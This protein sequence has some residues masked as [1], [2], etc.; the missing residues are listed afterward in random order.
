M[1]F[2]DHFSGHAS[3][4]A[5]ARPTYPPALFDWLAERCAERHLAWD[6]GC[7]NGQAALALASRFDHVYASDPSAEQIAAAPPDPRIRY[8]VEAAEACSLADASADL[9]TVAQAYHW[10]DHARFAEQA[11]R[12]LKPG[13][14]LAVFNYAR[15]SVCPEID[16][17][18]DHLHD[19]TLAAD[20]PPER[21]FAVDGFHHLPMPFPE[22][23]DHPPAHFRLHCDWTLDQYL[24]YL[25]SWSGCQRYLKRTGLDPIAAITPAMADAWGAP[26]QPRA[27]IWPL[28]LRCARKPGRLAGRGEHPLA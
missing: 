7:G 13:G 22:C 21:Y 18:F 20:W 11:R 25:R 10:F 1:T 12:V 2:K 23:S 9:I 5:A 17:L 8:A 14:L 27:V 3:A 24:A 15:S 26:D 28:T 4:Y 6:A 19:H 16:A